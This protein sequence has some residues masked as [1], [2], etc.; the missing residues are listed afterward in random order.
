MQVKNEVMDNR[1]E[2]IERIDCKESTVK[3]GR[4]ATQDTRLHPVK[5]SVFK[6]YQR[7]VQFYG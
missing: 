4:K 2:I 7:A 3:I 6:A 1:K 5:P